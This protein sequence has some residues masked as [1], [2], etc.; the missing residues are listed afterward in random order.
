MLQ[1]IDVDA[2]VQHGRRGR[3]QPGGQLDV[4][5]TTR[6]QR[7][8]RHPHHA[9]VELLGDRR[10]AVGVN[11]QIAATNIDLVGERQ[12]HRLAGERFGQVAVGGHDGRHPAAPARGERHDFVTRSHHAGGESATETAKIQMRSVDILHRK[13]EI[14]Q[15]AV[16]GD[17]DSFQFSQQS[18]SFVPRHG[19]GRL[20]HVVAAQRRYR[21]AAHVLDPELG[22]ELQV[23][24]A[25]PREYR[26]V[27]A[28]QIHFV[29]RQQQ[30]ANA[31]QGDDETVATSLSLHT[32][33]S[34]H[35]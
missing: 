19:G 10:Q 23:I 5:L 32:L 17:L 12:G 28:D 27:V 35:Q 7:R 24:V 31:E 33:A 29:D 25:N 9:S 16:G 13:T 3:Q 26:W 4:V 6:Q 15:V 22:H 11:Q 30:M 21:H 20:R 18:G 8:V 2:V 1:G 34:V 14:A